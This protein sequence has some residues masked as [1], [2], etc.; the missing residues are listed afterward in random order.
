MYGDINAGFSARD[1][2][3]AVH[4]R[5]SATDPARTDPAENNEKII[6]RTKI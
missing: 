3:G 6:I 2:A 5:S 1:P 4:K